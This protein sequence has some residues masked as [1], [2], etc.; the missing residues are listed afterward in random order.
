MEHQQTGGLNYDIPCYD[1]PIS[2]PSH[3]GRS[4]G[5]GY[6]I[7][8]Y[9]LPIPPPSYS[10]RSGGPG[11]D[12]PCHD[13][14]I[15]PPS[16]SDRSGGPGYDIPYSSRQYSGTHYYRAK[17]FVRRF[18]DGDG[19][20]LSPQQQT[21]RHIAVA[22]MVP[23]MI[24]RIFRRS[25]VVAIAIVRNRSCD[26]TTAAT[27]QQCRR[28]SKQLR[29]IAVTAAAPAMITR[30]LRQVTVVLIV[31]VRNRSH[32]ATAAVTVQHC[33]HS[34]SQLHGPSLALSGTR[35]TTAATVQRRSSSQAPAPSVALA[36]SRGALAAMDRR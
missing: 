27:V 28:S 8:Y 33:R 9:D 31:I 23:A 19:T 7:P 5:P 13:L 22:A 11:Y 14:P 1:L 35:G 4:G 3:S 25:T 21:I 34:S 12:I 16:C 15:S 36:G 26:A 30:V 18:S 17:P 32:D 10:G 2:P 20:A 6:D 29:H 24:S